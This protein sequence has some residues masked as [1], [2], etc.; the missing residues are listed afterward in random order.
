VSKF[1]LVLALPACAATTALVPAPASH[2]GAHLDLS[3]R[4]G[5]LAPAFPEAIEPALPSVDR[6]SREVRAQLGD[7]AVA[8]LDLCVSPAGKVTRVAIAKSSTL[9]AF[10][11]ALLHDAEHWQFDALPGPDTVQSCRRA[12]IE[13]RV[14]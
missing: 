2:T 9:A 8:D 7:T 11:A 1:L 14:R 3:A 5:S 6:I 12:T 10:D 13:Y 4:D